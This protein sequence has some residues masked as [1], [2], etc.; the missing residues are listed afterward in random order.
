MDSESPRA[1]SIALNAFCKVNLCLEITGRRDDGYHD[2]ATVF[3]T[4]SLG[5]RL[6]I[7]VLDEPLVEVLVPDGGAPEGEENLCWQAAELYRE[8]C[9]W[10][11]GA[12]ITLTKNVPSG[13][14]LGG[15]SSDAAAVLSGLASIDAAPPGQEVLH[16]L[17]ADL[18]ADVPFFLAGGTAF[19][20][21][22]GD[23]IV[24]LPALPA[25]RIVLVGPRLQI[26]TAE[27]YGM[28]DEDDFT[29]GARAL[30]MVTAIRED[31]AAEIPDHV[32]NGFARVLE[33]R[34]AALGELKR[35]LRDEGA[36]AAEITGSGSAVF[37]I[38]DDHATASA[39][40]RALAGQGHWAR[41]TE[42]VPCGTM[43]AG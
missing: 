19:A 7:E 13:A 18:G 30:A 5:D 32:F 39:A 27:A 28:L 17:A 36:I 21:G 29:D 40:G 14:G 41:L 38:F 22:R 8:E 43:V 34:W 24:S 37:G 33:G 25:C 2:L 11:N 3:Q 4:V 6:T 23:R 42:P 12:V 26:S 20:T 35:A 16:T 31:A 9:G 10:P 15:G 1:S